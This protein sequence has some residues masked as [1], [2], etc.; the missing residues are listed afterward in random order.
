MKLYRVKCRGMIDSHGTAFVVA[1][2]AD[3]AYRIVLVDLD[4][5]SLGFGWERE[6]NRVE[7][8]AEDTLYPACGC[9]LYLS[10]ETETA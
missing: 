9:R 7:L 6:M 10:P 5:R 4:A 1:A 2:N 8:V 3:A